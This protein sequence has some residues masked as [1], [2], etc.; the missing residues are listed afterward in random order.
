ME[1][2][3]TRQRHA[4]RAV[5][6]ETG[7]P[8]L[9]TEIMFLAQREVPS[10]GLATIYRNLK[11]MTESGEVK[12]VDIPGQ[13][14]RYEVQT[15]ANGGH[16]HHF[17]CTECERVFDIQACPGDM[18]HLLPKGFSVSHHDITLYGQCADCPSP[19]QSSKKSTTPPSTCNHV[20][21]PECGHHEPTK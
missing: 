13:A 4:I 15:D 19:E 11:S 5:L 10:I 9:P 3:F 14:P 7:R 21:G 17:Q 8:L 18:Q 12:V 2:R 1:Q 6:K 20:H 16:H